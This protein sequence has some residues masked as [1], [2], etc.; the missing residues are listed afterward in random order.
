MTTNIPKK[1]QLLRNNEYYSIQEQF[2]NLYAESSQS[3]VFDNLMPMIV[4]EQN[5]LLAYRNIK[6]NKGSMT[7]GVNKSTIVTLGETEPQRL[8]EYV[9]NRLSDFKPHAVRRVEIPKPD[10]KMRPLGIPTIEDRLIQQCIKQVLEPICEAK[11]YKHSYGFRP[12]RSAHHAIAR[13][14]FLVNIAKYRYVVDVDIKGFFDNVHHGKLL[15]Q[16]WTLGIRDKKLLSVISK[17]LKAR[18]HGIGIPDRGIPQGGIA[19][20]LY[21]NIVLNEL[22]WWIASQWD[23]FPNHNCYSCNEAKLS[24][25]HRASKLKPMYIVRYADDFK[26]FCRTRSDADKIFLAVK[27][28]LRERLKLEINP[29]KSKV[30][31]LKKH[32]SDF[33]GFKLKL[34]R[35]SNKWVLKSHISDKAQKKCRETIR[36]A[37]ALVGRAPNQQS[38]MRFNAT[39]LGLH[40]YYKIATN[41][42]LDFDRI[43]FD[44]RKMLLCRTKSHRTETGVKSRAFMTYYGDFTGKVFYIQK[45]ALFPVNGIG[46]SPPMCFSQ[47]ICNYTEEGRRKIHEQQK[48]ISPSVL[49]YLMENPIRGSSTEL[50]DNRISLYVAQRGKCAITHEPLMPH[51]MEVHH[52][53]PLENG[54]K[55]NYDN[56]MIVTA[57]VHKL[58]HA[59]RSETIEKYRNRLSGLKID[60]SRL[61]KLR[62]L[63]GNCKIEVNR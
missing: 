12:N 6:K 10:G 45:L 9:R 30:V 62:L 54:G 51:D 17:S 60:S 3:A 48:A 49:T 23:T 31:N 53:T 42:Y 26:I 58:I 22:D 63:V 56:L 28:W 8:V 44:V 5:I 14:M 47:K 52:K 40:N 41:V 57:D 1:K 24:A 19:S 2:D 39:V 46:T 61:N 7:K 29:E 4:S 50:N 36:E 59:V 25:L 15:K 35:K 38:V 33:L 13:A 20:T 18:I 16:M 37:I 55:D 34:R 32:Y 43:A 11:F 27:E 21:A